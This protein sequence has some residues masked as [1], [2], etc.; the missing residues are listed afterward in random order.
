M[1]TRYATALATLTAAALLTACSSTP[2]ANDP[3]PTASAPTLTDEQRNSAA[4]A[5]GMPPKPTGAKRAELL[6]ALAKVAPD[7]VKYED[8]AIDAA[9]NQC[10][11]INGQG[12]RLDW[13]ASQ[14][15]T[16]E[17]V[18]TTE[19][20]GKEINAALKRIGFCDV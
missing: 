1:R 19:A 10:F 14:R 17:D 11:G 5:V 4:A 2:E 20:Q 3:M 18:T 9:R 8:K 16:Y 13:S 15:F 6:A 12:K 7:V